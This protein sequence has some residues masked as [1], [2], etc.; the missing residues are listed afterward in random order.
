MV[1]AGAVFAVAGAWQTRGAG[2]AAQAL[3]TA[4]DQLN[5]DVDTEA[6]TSSADTFASVEERTQAA[7]ASFEKVDQE[8]G[9]T[10]AASWAKLGLARAYSEAGDW[11]KAAAAY[12]AAIKSAD[13][14]ETITWLAL[15]GWVGAQH[16]LDKTEA[17]LTRL[18]GFAGLSPQIA[19]MLAFQQGKIL[20]GQGKKDEAKA[21]LLDVL[22]RL[23]KPGAPALTLTKRQTE[24]LLGAH[25][26]GPN[27]DSEL[28]PGATS[29][30]A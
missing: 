29:A 13:G 25:R 18:N 2:Q 1:V 26:P 10:A 4:V 11:D 27:Q 6:Q 8:H 23:N 7:I 3:S 5:A 28:R 9:G 12:D 19:P 24:N 22:E 30:S 14:D 15:D 17:A 16:A 20:W 21:R